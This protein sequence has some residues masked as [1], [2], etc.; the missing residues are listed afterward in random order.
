MAA[1]RA[2]RS[3]AEPPS[4]FRPAGR[5][6]RGP[7]DI[8]ILYLTEESKTYALRALINTTTNT[9]IKI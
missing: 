8:K 3:A 2:E 5:G 6:R 7:T 9:T 1:L 4:N